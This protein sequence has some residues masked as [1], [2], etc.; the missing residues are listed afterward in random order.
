MAKNDPDFRGNI[1][2]RIKDA[3]TQ[4]GWVRAEVWINDTIVTIHECPSTDKAIMNARADIPVG[5]YGIGKALG[6]TVRKMADI[7][8]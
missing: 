2:L 6:N 8:S 7:T 3:E 4:P 1:V 5:Q